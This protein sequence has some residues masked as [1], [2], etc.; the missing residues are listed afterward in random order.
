MKSALPQPPVGPKEKPISAR[1]GPAHR[2]GATAEQTRHT[3]EQ[4]TEQLQGVPRGGGGRSGGTTS[5]LLCP[6]KL[7]SKLHIPGDGQKQDPKLRG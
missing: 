5:E 3:W 6:V 2:S 1:P 4:L 7:D